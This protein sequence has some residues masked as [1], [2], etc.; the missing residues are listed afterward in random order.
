M[1]REA[2]R[3]AYV[4]AFLCTANEAVFFEDSLKSR[5]ASRH[6]QCRQVDQS[7]LFLGLSAYKLTFVLTTQFNEF[8]AN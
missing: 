4:F 2:P 7:L 8:A 3:S 1:Q 6:F 5:S